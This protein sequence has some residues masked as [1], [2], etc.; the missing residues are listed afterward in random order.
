MECHFGL[1]QNSPAEHLRISW[2][3][4]T[5]VGNIENCTNLCMFC[6]VFKHPVVKTFNT[7][8]FVFNLPHNLTY[9]PGEDFICN[10]NCVYVYN[11]H[12]SG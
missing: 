1:I 12:E 6:S 8:M 5:G 11:M 9:R 3:Y 7:I 10:P 2:I 4:T